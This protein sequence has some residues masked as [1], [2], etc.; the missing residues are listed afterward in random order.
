MTYSSSKH[1]NA[2][3]Q[4]NHD[5]S[6]HQMWNRSKTSISKPRHF[7]DEPHGLVATLL[8]QSEPKD[9]KLALKHLGWVEAMDEELSALRANHT[10]QLVPRPVR[11]NI[12]GSKWVYHTKYL[13]DGTVDRLKARL[14]AQGFYQL[15]GLDYT[16]TF[17]PV[18]KAATIRTVLALAVQHNW[19]LNRLDV[20]NAF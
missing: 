15:P 18:V 14:V 3:T 13:F 4:P 19:S 10:W 20:K 9:I 17:S 8:A 16:H 1:A 2:S 7:P 11:V 5:G 12:V 6:R